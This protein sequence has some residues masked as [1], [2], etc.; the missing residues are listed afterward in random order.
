MTLPRRILIV[1]DNRAVARDLELRLDRL[2]FSV[3]GVAASGEQAIAIAERDR[4]D[5][6]LM[7]IRLSGFWTISRMNG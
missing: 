4:P 7:D 5:L 6:A 2:G 1:E 3:A